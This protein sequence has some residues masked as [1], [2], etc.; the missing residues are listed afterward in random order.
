MTQIVVEILVELLLILGA[1]TMMFVA[2]W[3]AVHR[4]RAAATLRDDGAGCAA[5]RPQSRVPTP[6]V[7]DRGRQTRSGPGTG[8]GTGAAPPAYAASVHP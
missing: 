2:L 6:T 8:D 4:A 1:V 5:G 3:P 7:R